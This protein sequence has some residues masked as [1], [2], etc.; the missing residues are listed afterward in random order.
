MRVLVI[1]QYWYPE[2]GVPQRR[3]AWL[4]ELMSDSGDEVFVIAPPANYQR[5]VGFREWVFRRSFRPTMESERGPSGEM[6]L[7]T[8][9][10][11]FRGSLTMKAL[12]QM[13]VALG[14]LRALV[15]PH[16]RLKQF[17]PEIIIGTV[18]AL[19]TAFVARI[20]ALMYGLPYII[21]LRDAW[22]DLLQQ[23]SRWNM[24]LD[25][26]SYK[27]KILSADVRGISPRT[28]VVYIV[29]R[30]LNKALRSA[31][32][33]VVTASDLG[34]EFRERFSGQKVSNHIVT[35]R[36]VF[37]NRA[38]EVRNARREGSGL[39]ANKPTL[40][41]LY[42]GTIG[43]AQNLL[44]A[45]EAAK[46]AGERGIDISLK[47]V[48]AGAARQSVKRLAAREGVN[49]E[50]VERTSLKDISEHYLWADTAL[51][52]L[53]DW[54]PLG[55]TVP[56]KTY[57]LMEMGIH[58]TGVVEGEAARIIQQLNAG[59]VA[60]PESP[61]LLAAI[62]EKLSEDKSLLKV[63]NAG[64]KWVEN[65]RRRVADSLLSNLLKEVQ[66]KHAISKR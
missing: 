44:N 38:Q 10:V 11:P 21:D 9:Y 42:A 65:E 31:N 54:E 59:H 40:K 60:P 7:R 29:E 4:T 39:S 20:A 24:G 62:W 22:P 63:S 48:G 61:E 58:I 41:V 18:P 19:P 25:R 43:R 30:F 33:L 49:A 14:M 56:S 12:N 3:W 27:E 16:K 32:G 57:E 15:L 23:S 5:E 52:H 17:D 28:L 6:I 2:Q 50:F 66:I 35:I 8:G 37:P 64:Q 1:S 34:N 36:N 47:F 26:R 51:V 53:T 45:I 55:R 46:I 13:T